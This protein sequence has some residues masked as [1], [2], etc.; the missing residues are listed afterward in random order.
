MKKY[1]LLIITI[2]LLASCT[3][4]S[5]VNV[6]DD[7]VKVNTDGV[8]VEVSEEGVSVD[9]W[10]EIKE[11]AMPEEEKIVEEEIVS[12]E[13]AWEEIIVEEV[14][15]PAWEEDINTEWDVSVDMLLIKWLIN[16][17]K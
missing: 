7:W 16:Y 17:M 12:E 4:N 1:F 5:S 2:L 9:T 13:P 11:E 15:E 14:E 8:N 6:S 10:K 3:G